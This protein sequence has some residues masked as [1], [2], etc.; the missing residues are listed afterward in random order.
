MKKSNLRRSILKTAGLLP[1]GSML[2]LVGNAQPI[3]TQPSK[4]VPRRLQKGSVLGIVAPAS[5]VKG[6]R[7]EQAKAVLKKQGF[8]FKIGKY[9][10]H[11]FGYFAGTD[12]ERAEDLMEMFADGEVDAILVAQGGWGCSRILPYLNFEVIAQNPKPLI[13]FSDVTALLLAIQGKTGTIT[14]HGPNALS[15]WNHFTTEGFTKVLMEGER[16]TYRGYPEGNG[17]ET[18]ER[19]TIVAG[20]AT[21]PLIGGNLT[22]MT[23]LLG[24]AY[25]PDFKGALLVLEDIDEAV[26]KIDRMITHLKL[27]GKLA[28]VN[29]IVFTSCNACSAGD[30]SYAFSLRKML[31]DQLKPLGKPAFF[32][33]RMGHVKEKYTFPIGIWAKMDAAAGII[34]LLEDPVK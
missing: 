17:T 9:I 30:E 18:D 31:N 22:V 28:Q 14:Y 34:T 4:Q 25:L 23:T 10:T 24:S 13:G 32:G 33:M 8:R 12:Q 21:G 16:L 2:P 26:Y 15:D 20:Q 3:S 29:G 1:L 19:F 27:A 5:I 11:K 7:L 6:N